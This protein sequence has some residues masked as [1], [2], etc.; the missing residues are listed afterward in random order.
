MSHLEPEILALMAMGESVA[1]PEDR[2]HI[3]DCPECLS[4]LSHLRHAVT[5]GRAT[6]DV[7]ELETPDAAVWSRIADEVQLSDEARR[8]VPPLLPVG[9]SGSSMPRDSAS[10]PIAGPETRRS[11]RRPTRRFIASRASWVLAVSLALVVGVGVVSWTIVRHLAPAPIAQAALAAFPDHPGASGSAVVDR[12]RDGSDTVTVTLNA[13]NDPNGYHEVWLITADASALVSLG[14]LDGSE[15]T[16]TI[17]PGIDLNQ[18]RL[19]DIS[20]EP[21]DGDPTHSG[22]SIVRGQLAFG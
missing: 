15:G 20:D 14:V 12:D 17:P 10:V 16:F 13:P 19:V 8:V 2:A 5:V 3:E 1:S 4:E 6:L 7:G 22:D 11:R 21:V 9:A 18:Y